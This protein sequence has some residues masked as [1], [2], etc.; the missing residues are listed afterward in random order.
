MLLILDWDFFVPMLVFF[1]CV[2]V[3]WSST[4]DAASGPVF[5]VPML[6]YLDVQSA[7]PFAP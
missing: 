2:W 7:S 4:C 1:F 6:V 3:G 5:F